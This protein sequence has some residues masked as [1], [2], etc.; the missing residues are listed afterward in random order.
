[1]C[2]VSLAPAKSRV[3]A[4]ETPNLYGYSSESSRVERQWE[5]KMRAIPDSNNL[6]AYMERLTAR[7]HNVGSPYDKDNAEWILSKFKEFGLDAQIESFSV[8]YPTPKERLVEL[9]DG[10]PH[11]T[12]KLQEPAVPE[13][14]TSSQTAEQ[15]PTY[16]AYSVDGDVTAPLVYVSGKTSAAIVPFGV[17]PGNNAQV[18]VEYNGQFTNA[19]TMPVTNGVPGVYSL[20]SSGSGQGAVWKTTLV[21]GARNVPGSLFR[22]LSAFALRDVSLTKIESRP[23]RGRPWEYLFYLDL[24]GRED[25]PHVRNALNHLRELADFLRVLGCYPKGA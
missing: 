4:D 7:P 5:E 22:A 14:P 23:L 19:V 11:F 10:G 24:I 12:A 8:L 25:A 15:L 16:N 9:V 6:R 21:F 18:Q 1:M 17:S 20:D 2:A 3:T 13:D